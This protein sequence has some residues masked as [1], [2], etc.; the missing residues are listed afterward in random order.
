MQTENGQCRLLYGMPETIVTQ[1]LKKSLVLQKCTFR[2][3]AQK[4]TWHTGICSAWL[5]RIKLINE[6]SLDSVKNI[7]LIIFLTDTII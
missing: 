7:Y 6:E 3:K 1:K 4:A 2:G 5:L